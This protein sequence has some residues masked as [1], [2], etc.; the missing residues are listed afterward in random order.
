MGEWRYI[1]IILDLTWRWE[2]SFTL[3]SLYPLGKLSRY[4]FEM[5][6]GGFQNRSGNCKTNNLALV[7]IRTCIRKF[8]SRLRRISL[9]GQV[10]VMIRKKTCSAGY[11]IRTSERLA[12]ILTIKRFVRRVIS[13]LTDTTVSF[14]IPTC[15]QSMTFPFHCIIYSASHIQWFLVQWVTCLKSHGI[16]NR[17]LNIPTY[18]YLAKEFYTSVSFWFL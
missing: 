14:Q 17:M 12:T 8:E 18:K 4:Q 5:R 11:P 9:S 10:R 13:V 7:G 6:L 3:L 16:A 1:S 15:S 2:V